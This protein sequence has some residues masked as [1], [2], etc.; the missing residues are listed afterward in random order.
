LDQTA[1]GGGEIVAA[2]RELVGVEKIKAASLDGAD[3]DW[4]RSTERTRGRDTEGPIS[5][6]EARQ[7]S[8]GVLE[9]LHRTSDGMHCSVPC[10]ALAL[11]PYEKAVG[12][13]GIPGRSVVKK[14]EV[15]LIIDRSVT[16]RASANE[17]YSASSVVDC[18]RASRAGAVE[19]NDANIL[20]D[21]GRRAGVDHDAGAVERERTRTDGKSVSW[22]A[23]IEC[24]STDDRRPPSDRQ[25]RDGGWAEERGAGARRYRSRRPII[26]VRV[27]RRAGSE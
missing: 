12:D 25:R 15:A 3:R 13:R 11:E 26:W 18:G 24:P 17:I 20:V 4:T 2:S 10:G 14:N 7:A 8:G 6:G 16:G 19:S 27:K 1:H 5:I 23:G 22:R 21:D 9:E